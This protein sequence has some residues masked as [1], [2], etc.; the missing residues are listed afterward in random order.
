MWTI[1]YGSTCYF[2]LKPITS[3][4]APITELQAKTLLKRDIDAVVGYLNE[5]LKDITLTQNQFD[6]ICSLTY[7]IGVGNFRKSNLLKNLRNGKEV[8]K[9]NFV[10][11]NKANGKVI[12]GLINRRQKEWEVFN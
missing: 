2:D 7:N 3:H 1:G 10:S 12:Q 6:A 4:T 11:W 8:V 5:D 9:D